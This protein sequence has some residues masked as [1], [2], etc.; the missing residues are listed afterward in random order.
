LHTDKRARAV[1]DGYSGRLE[2]RVELRRANLAGS[3][4]IKK[5]DQVVKRQDLVHP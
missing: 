4:G 3:I 5:H 1:F 2:Q